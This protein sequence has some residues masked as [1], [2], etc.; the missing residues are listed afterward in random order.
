MI[1][2]RS[3]RPA[4]L[5]LHPPSTHHRTADDVAVPERR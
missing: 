5:L 2:H 4:L 3:D 1:D